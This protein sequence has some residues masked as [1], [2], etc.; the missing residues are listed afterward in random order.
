MKAFDLIIS[1]IAEEELESIVNYTTLTFGENQAS[2]YL[3]QLFESFHD[4]Q[5][6]PELGHSRTD[7]PKDYL[8][9]NVGQH[10]VIYLVSKKK[11]R[12]EI[13]R[14]LHARMNFSQKF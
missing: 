10:C 1:Q 4:L 7:I 6:Q 5:K 2:I 12:I 11:K 9:Y 3:S 13:T 8:C 14:I